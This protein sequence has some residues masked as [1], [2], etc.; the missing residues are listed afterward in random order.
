MS[1]LI[2]A[3]VKALDDAPSNSN[4]FSENWGMAM[5][6][7]AAAQHANSKE[8]KKDNESKEVKKE[9]AEVEEE[10]TEEELLLLELERE[11]AIKLEEAMRN[12]IN[13][14]FGGNSA[15]KNAIKTVRKQNNNLYLQEKTVLDE[16]NFNYMKND[17]KVA[18]FRKQEEFGARKRIKP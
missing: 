17:V 12:M 16:K 8:K 4:Q 1:D 2:N 10:L 3:V 6:A 11:K 14:R 13:K 7:L 18:G 9:E 15:G 5:G